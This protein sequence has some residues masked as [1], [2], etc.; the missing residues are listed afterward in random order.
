MHE[1]EISTWLNE[2]HGS[3]GKTEEL[4]Q[5]AEIYRDMTT[6]CKVDPGLDS[7]AINDIPGTIGGIKLGVWS[8]QLQYVRV[9]G[10]SLM[11]VLHLHRIMSSFVGIYAKTLGSDGVSRQ[12]LSLK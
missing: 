11:A 9:N 8:R 1:K 12:Q 5:I 4:F 6:Q 3:Q 7:L 10:L 2:C